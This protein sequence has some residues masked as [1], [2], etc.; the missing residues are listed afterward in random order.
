MTLSEKAHLKRLKALERTSSADLEALLLLDFQSPES[1]EAEIDKILR[2]AEILAERAHRQNSGDADRAW[3]VFLEKYLPFADANSLYKSAEAP[4]AS[5][6]AVQPRP[7]SS[8][9]LR[10]QMRRQFRAAGHPA[11]YRITRT[12]ACIALSLL[13]SGVL[14]LT[15]SPDARSVFSGWIRE[16]C[17]DHFEY[18]YA[19]SGKPAGAEDHI[20]IDRPLWIPE[21]YTRQYSGGGI[22][23]AKSLYTS[24]DSGKLYYAYATVNS[25]D[26]ENAWPEIE[27]AVAGLE[28]QES[29]INGL[30]AHL[31]RQTDGSGPLVW[32]NSLNDL[33]WISG[34]LTAEELVRMAESVMMGA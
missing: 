32:G 6:V 2:A 27:S 34:P 23:C 24:E 28:A 16:I 5:A 25:T 17:G 33:Y 21:G 3:K 1:S 9:S 26:W 8:P 14:L 13:L 11:W 30:P 4:G 12:A 31:Y 29:L 19:P 10:R 22:S 20:V 18:H 7:A 15:F